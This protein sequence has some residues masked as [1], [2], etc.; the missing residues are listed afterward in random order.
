MYFGGCVEIRVL[1]HLFEEGLLR[2]A[3]VVPAPMENDRWLL[4]FEKSNGGQE[5]ITKARTDK[6][7]VYKRLYG[8]LSDAQEIG[9]KK[10]TIEYP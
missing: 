8:A 7:K 10:I 1:K 5:K 2:T 9:F 6:Q 4:M 3:I